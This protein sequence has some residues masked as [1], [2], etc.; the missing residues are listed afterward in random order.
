[1][2][3][4]PADCT[5]LYCATRERNENLVGDTVWHLHVVTSSVE[6][7]WW[8]YSKTKVQIVYDLLHGEEISFF[9]K[10]QNKK[11]KQK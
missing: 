11:Q 8:D 2:Y 10:K 3:A 5:H 9:L 1:M 4:H 7:I 6:N